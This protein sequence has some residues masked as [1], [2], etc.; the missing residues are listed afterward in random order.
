MGRKIIYIEYKGQ[1]YL[2]SNRINKYGWGFEKALTTLSYRKT[3][4]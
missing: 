4:K 2:I 1:I 3:K